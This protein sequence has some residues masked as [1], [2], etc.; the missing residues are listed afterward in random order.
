MNQ[1]N[2]FDQKAFDNIF[3]TESHKLSRTDS[4]STS[5]DAARL[6]DTKSLEH[7]VLGTITA[8]GNRGC[9]S[10]DVLTELHGMPY[11]SVTARYKSL[12]DKGLIEFTGEIRSGKSGRGQR[13]MRATKSNILIF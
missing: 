12:A 9:I 3:G 5:K 1:I 4:P 6:V 10:D 11:S 2:L 13:V 8:F 7:L